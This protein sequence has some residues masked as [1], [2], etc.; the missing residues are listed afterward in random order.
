[1]DDRTLQ[2][3]KQHLQD[4][5]AQNRILKNIERGRSEATV[6][7]GRA[8]ELFG[9]TE[10][11]LRDWE[12]RGL[13]CPKKS[14]GG[15]RLYPLTELDRLAVIREL[16]NAK[17]SPGD[18]PKDINRIWYALN[19][20]E[21][22]KA[23]TSVSNTGHLPI[24][25]RVD[26]NDRDVFWQ[27]FV[28]QVLRISL[29]LICEDMP[30]T[31]AGLVLPLEQTERI[32]SHDPK[33][34]QRIGLSLVGW[35]TASRTFHA[36]LDTAPSFEFPSDFRLEHFSI[37]GSDAFPFTPY[38]VIQRKARPI[39]ISSILTETVYRLLQFVYSHLNDWKPCFDFGMQDWVYQ[40]T[41]FTRGTNV[42]DLVLNGL[43]D[44]IVELGS[45]TLTGNERW[46]FADLF[47]PIDDSLP[48]QQQSLIARAYS[49]ESPVRINSIN[50][51]IMST[52]NL[53]LTFRAYQ[54][55]HIIYRPIIS[56]QDHI[57]AYRDTEGETRSA[58][59]IPISGE[60][61]IAIAA[62]YIASRYE[63]AFTNADLRILRVI[64]RMIE[65]LLPT[66]RARQNVPSKLS[67]LLNLPRVVDLAFR[68]FQ[69]EDD[70]ID[71]LE[72]FL[73]IIQSRNDIEP[74]G[75]PESGSDLWTVTDEAASFIEVDIDNQ[76]DLAM[77]YGDRVARNL[78]KAVGQRIQGQ[79]RIQSN[80]DYRKVH[81]INADK[82]F[83][84]FVGMSLEDARE[85]AEVM[86]V[87]LT[88]KY[89]IDAR[90]IVSGRP[91]S[92]ENLLELPNVTVRLAV[93]N[94]PYSKLKELLLRSS[95]DSA[96]T[97]LRAII[98]ENMD[99]S[100]RMGQSLG[101]NCIVT[102]VHD[103][104]GHRRWMPVVETK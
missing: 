90:R 10:N 48:L 75:G 98:M 100:L 55:G 58:T 14:A 82:F 44:T 52:Y 59:A 71:D 38:L 19:P 80:P 81:H 24:D 20:P 99:T 13:I 77:K 3:I 62:L 67:E 53:G 69:S 8:A 72:E 7:I 88:G 66:Y 4:R 64:S 83:M 46:R 79:L 15:Q 41:D 102:W 50:S 31:V 51:I 68:E 34:L 2:S 104:W 85:L 12:V 6:T 36:F 92:R 61:G 1:M 37:P 33:D 89:R 39:A 56:Q 17:F 70:F 32:Y 103:I 5:D 96:V 57:L 74:Q 91:L 86:H 45:K 42:N 40:I 87:Q 30:D 9:F 23:S 73:T 101:G 47:L 84:K 26:R 94:Y 97:E 43:M 21:G 25:Q 76:A 22:R 54:S 49:K 35:I 93:Q 65:E 11:Q 28:S 78:S 16:L 18:I 95:A 60:N 63:E 27:Y 29:L